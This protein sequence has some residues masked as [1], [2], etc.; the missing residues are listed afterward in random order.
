[1]FG[2]RKKD[3]ATERDTSR[4]R[5]EEP[6]DER[7]RKECRDRQLNL[8][9]WLTGASKRKEEER[10]GKQRNGMGRERKREEATVGGRSAAWSGS[11]PCCAL[12]CGFEGKAEE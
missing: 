2:S 12:C 4:W 10:E 3:A 8:R 9:R 6:S 11:N 5:R 7:E 1:L